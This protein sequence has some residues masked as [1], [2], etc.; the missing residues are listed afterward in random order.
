MAFKII[1]VN[2]YSL[3][4]NHGSVFSQWFPLLFS[5]VLN[6]GGNAN[7]DASNA[8]QYGLS[9]ANAN[10]DATNQNANIGSRL[11][12]IFIFPVIKTVPSRQKTRKH[13]NQASN[14]R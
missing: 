3:S 1:S 14:Y 12:L 13:T 7:T 6:V 5:R 11:I 10:N 4:T 9:Y 2:R 8:L